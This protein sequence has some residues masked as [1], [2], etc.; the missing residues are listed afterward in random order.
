MTTKKLKKRTTAEMAR[1]HTKPQKVGSR[2][3]SPGVIHEKVFPDASP[4]AAQE[5]PNSLK[6][7]TTLGRY[8]FREMI[9]PFVISVSFFTFIFLL[10]KI[11]DIT[12]LIVN[13][14]AGLSS[15]FLMLLYLMPY[16]LVFVIPISVMMS[17]LLTFLR[18]SGDNETLAIKAGGI[19]LYQLIPP[20]FVFCLIGC[21]L[22]GGMTLYGLPWGKVSLKQLTLK[23]ATSTFSIGLKERTFNE[24]VKDVMLYVNQVD[25]KNNALR[26]VF[27]QDQRTKDLVITIVS[28]KGQ[29]FRTSG[30][31][32][33][34]LKLL[35]GTVNQVDIQ[36]RSANTVHFDTYEVRLDLEQA[37]KKAKRRIRN[38]KEMYLSELLQYVWKGPEKDSQ[39]Y[40]VL[41][42]LNRKFSIP[43]ACFV[44]GLLA[45]PLGVQAKSARRAFGLSLGLVF[46]LLY[47]LLLS[48]GLVFGESGAY[49]PL[50]GMWMPNLVIGGIGCYLFVRVANDRPLQF[51]R[52]YAMLIG[53]KIQKSKKTGKDILTA[54]ERK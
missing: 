11:L 47:Y 1:R 54:N 48:A 37:M 30:K 42:E 6:I 40:K 21:L 44:F 7:S 51:P 20:V 8:L 23:L 25:L 32:V 33:I 5:R 53:K 2:T 26:D 24:H 16:F 39:Y 38:E 27:I 14:R 34:H 22:T 29:L 31:S 17:V 52:I 9:P 19:S 49:P 50:I 10:T 36:K 3:S 35:N 12:N 13:Y 45:I 4:K 15:V 18:M 46:F 41:L 43:M 28:P